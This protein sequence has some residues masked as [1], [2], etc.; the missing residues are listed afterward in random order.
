MTE[1]D[2]GV[3]GDGPFRVRDHDGKEAN[4]TGRVPVDPPQ[5][6]LE[7]LFDE[8]LL[9]TIQVDQLTELPEKEIDTVSQ[10][11]D[12]SERMRLGVV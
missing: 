11:I 3:Y 2:A 9:G 6:R 8:D 12:E 5:V 1:R 4:R 10:E 7:Q